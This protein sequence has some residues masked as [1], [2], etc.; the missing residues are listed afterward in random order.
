MCGAKLIDKKNTDEYAEIK[1]NCGKIGWDKKNVEEIYINYHK[2]KKVSSVP[3]RLTL[4]G[5]V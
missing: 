1:I 4:S 2:Q 5:N 3:T